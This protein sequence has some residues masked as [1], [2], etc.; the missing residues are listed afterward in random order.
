LSKV[1]YILNL[2]VGHFLP[3]GR[4]DLRPDHPTP[5]RSDLVPDHPATDVFLPRFSGKFEQGLFTP[6]LGLVLVLS[7]IEDSRLI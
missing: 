1:K 3:A 6:P 2:V 5:G 4:S 7:K